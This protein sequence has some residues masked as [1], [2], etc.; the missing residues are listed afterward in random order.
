MYCT[1]PMALYIILQ[2]NIAL[3]NELVFRVCL[4]KRRVDAISI[5]PTSM[6]ERPKMTCA[7]YQAL[8]RHIMNERNKKKQGIV[9]LILS[10]CLHR[11]FKLVCVF[12]CLLLATTSLAFDQTASYIFE[13]LQLMSQLNSYTEDG[14]NALSVWLIFQPDVTDGK[15]ILQPITARELCEISTCDVIGHLVNCPVG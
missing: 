12:I 2:Y 1:F 11:I 9:S 10:Q 14:V 13:W 15:L 7:M 6:I 4:G 8:K 5:M 3:Q